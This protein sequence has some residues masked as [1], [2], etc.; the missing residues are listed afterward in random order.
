MS[1]ERLTGTVNLTTTLQYQFRKWGDAYDANSITNVRIYPTYND[2]VNETNIIETITT[3]S[4]IGTGLYEYDVAP[5]SNAGIYYDKI[6]LV[7]DAGEDPWTDIS[8]FTIADTGI[9]PSGETRKGYAF[10]NPDFT[11]KGNWGA[12]IHPDEL[13]YVYAFGNE[14]VAPNFQ[15]ITDETLWWYIDNAVASLE[16]DLNVTI[17][18]RIYRYRP[19]PDEDRTTELASLGTAGI[20]YEWTEPYDY[21]VR[22]VRQYMYIKLRKRPIIS[23]DKALWRDPTGGNVADILSW[24]KINYEKGSLEFFPSAGSLASLPLSYGLGMGLLTR[25]SRGNQRY[26]DAFFLDYTVGLESVKHLKKKWPELFAVVGMLSAINLLNDYGDGRSPGLASS[27][28]SLAGI[29]E[30]FSTTQSA[31]NALFGARILN[32]E[33]QLKLFYKNNKNKY[34]GLLIGSL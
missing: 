18:K 8:S 4:K 33:K 24:A 1:S 28:V 26:P 17:M 23:L 29:S 12:I 34:S 21:D 7:P 27:S 10:N 32:F 25:T 11:S 30:S 3:I 31:T 22:L 13:R 9:A 2:A 16:K 14:L 15:T 5:I 19:A 6:T 20:D